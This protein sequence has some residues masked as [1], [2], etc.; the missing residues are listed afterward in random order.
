MTDNRMAVI[1][2]AS[3]G[4]GKAFAHKCASLNYNLLLIARNGQKLKSTADT[5][6]REYNVKCRKITADLSVDG[7]V[8]KLVKVIE[9]EREISMLVNNAGFAIPQKLVQSDIHRQLDMVKVHIIAVVRLTRAALKRLIEK[10]SGSIIN[11]A[12]TLAFASFPNNSIY[13][14]S[15]AFINSFTKTLYYEYLNSGIAFQALNPGLT[16]TN[17]HNTEAFKHIRMERSDDKIAMSPEDVVEYSFSKLGKQVIAVPGFLNRFI[18]KFEGL[19]TKILRS[20]S[21]AN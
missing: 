17:F 5:L 18:I 19:F 1:T 21:K 3:S 6:T 11:V 7:D 14:A 9:N 20:K 13:C 2:G 4:I 16:K 10:K 15:K 12:S 8:D